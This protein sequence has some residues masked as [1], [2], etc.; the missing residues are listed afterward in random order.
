MQPASPTSRFLRA[1]P[2]ESADRIIDASRFVELPQKTQLYLRGERPRHLFLLTTGI[3]SVVYSSSHGSTLELETI[4]GEGLVGWNFLL[5]ASPSITDCFIQI[6]ATGYRVPFAVLEQEF[7]ESEAFRRY[8]LEF[9]QYES[10]QA[11]QIAV[12]NRL[13]Q[14]EARYARWLLMV[15]DRIHSDKL[16]LTQEFLS[17]MLGT[18]RTTVAEVS[19]ELARAGIIESR[20]GAVIIRSRAKLEARTCECYGVL[21]GLMTR[22]Y[23]G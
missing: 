13:H 18:R 10:T 8:V 9:V 1:I 5:G 17:T 21:Q 3:A 12:C 19:S 6:A 4:G 14:A 15:Q 20:R 11:Q 22:L 16:T 23:E 2:A 7:R